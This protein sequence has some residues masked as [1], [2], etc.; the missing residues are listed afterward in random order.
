[1]EPKRI[2]DEKRIRAISKLHFYARRL[3]S[4]R[5]AGHETYDSANRHI[6]N[7]RSICN[8]L[9]SDNEARRIGTPS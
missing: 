6:E 2:T 4:E 7:I 5:L 3:C 1:M 8:V 9:D